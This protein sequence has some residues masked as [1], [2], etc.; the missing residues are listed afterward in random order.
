MSP[1]TG[2]IRSAACHLETDKRE[3]VRF[4]ERFGHEVIGNH[5]VIGVPNWFMRC[6]ARAA[7]DA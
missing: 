5:Q 4:Y 7:W 6:P 2:T 1:R 3:N